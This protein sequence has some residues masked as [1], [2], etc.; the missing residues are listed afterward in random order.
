MTPI[1]I[2]AVVATVLALLFAF[3]AAIA[4]GKALHRDDRVEKKLE[5]RA[6]KFSETLASNGFTLAPPLI[7]DAVLHDWDKFDH[8]LEHAEDVIGNEEKLR[9]DLKKIQDTMNTKELAN[10]KYAQHFLDSIVH[11]AE[12][13]HIT[14]TGYVKAPKPAAPAPAAA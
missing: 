13:N 8:D 9:L 5:A 2:Y 10:H 11:Q 1:E 6:L 14:P 7:R 4:I 12:A 3:V